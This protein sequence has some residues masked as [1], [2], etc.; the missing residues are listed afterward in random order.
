M[1]SLANARKFS[2]ILSLL[3]LVGCSKKVAKVEALPGVLVTPAPAPKPTPK[4]IE[5]PQ[6][7]V[8]APAPILPP[9]IYFE[10][11]KSD[12]RPEEVRKLYR[13]AQNIDSRETLRVEGHADESGSAEYNLALGERRARIVAGYLEDAAFSIG[14]VIS[15]GEERPVHSCDC[16]HPE[17]RRVEIKGE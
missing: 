3:A 10:W 2:V 9:V 17:N 7:P 5:V 12:L 6:E 15:Y 14:D 4:P 8:I 11:D 16:K 13:F 1:L